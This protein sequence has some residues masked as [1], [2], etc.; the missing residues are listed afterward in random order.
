MIYNGWSI[1]KV[2]GFITI[3][4]Y[5]AQKQDNWH[6]AFLLRDCKKFCDDRDNG[7]EIEELYLRSLYT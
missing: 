3:K 5:V 7:K 6:W 4:R 1:N 2:G